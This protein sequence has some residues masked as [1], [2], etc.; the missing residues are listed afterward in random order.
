L[1]PEHRKK[2]ALERLQDLNPFAVIA[3]NQDLVRVLRIAW[4]E[5]AVN[6]LDAGQKA[7]RSPEW[8]DIQ[9]AD[10]NRFH[11]LAIAQLRAIRDAT[12]DRRLA[13]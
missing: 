5:A 2:Q 3:D 8:T 13:A 10:I 6:V 1:I 7:A 9:R 4:I 12:F 11:K